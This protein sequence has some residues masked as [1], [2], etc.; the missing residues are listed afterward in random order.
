MSF[1][2]NS[3]S[4]RSVRTSFSD[5]ESFSTTSRIS[6][7]NRLFSCKTWAAVCGPEEHRGLLRARLLQGL[8]LAALALR[9][10]Q[11][12]P[13]PGAAQRGLCWADPQ[14][15]GPGPAKAPRMHIAVP[16]A[17]LAQNAQEECE[18]HKERLGVTPLSHL[19][20][21]GRERAGEQ[22]SCPRGG[23]RSQ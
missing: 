3:R 17:S 13:P 8:F 22:L 12:V 23:R 16:A 6:F 19:L 7:C 20:N 15:R 9:D 4:F 5:S 18:E 11:G 2:T 1:S 10:T 14:L 21:E